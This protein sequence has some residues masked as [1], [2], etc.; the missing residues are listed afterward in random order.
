MCERVKPTATGSTLGAQAAARRRARTHPALVLRIGGRRDVR[1]GAGRKRQLL[2]RTQ[3]RALRRPRVWEG[4]PGR[5]PERCIEAIPPPLARQ[6]QSVSARRTALR[7][8]LSRAAP[9]QESMTARR[10]RA[11]CVLGVFYNAAGGARRGARQDTH[12]P[13]WDAHV[14]HEPARSPIRTRSVGGLGASSCCP[15]RPAVPEKD[16]E[17]SAETSALR[18]V[19]RAAPSGCAKNALGARRRRGGAGVVLGGALRRRRER[20]AARA[21]PCTA[22]GSGP[23]RF[24]PDTCVPAG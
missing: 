23:R 11:G 19:E 10:S 16:G 6:A 15:S 3:R 2:G 12:E 5:R 18:L 21:A 17:F 1:A 4:R 14:Q 13:T 24:Q 9:G 22:P 7:R 20:L 8:A